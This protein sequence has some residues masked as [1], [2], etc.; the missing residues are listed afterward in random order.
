MNRP[1]IAK[2]RAAIALLIAVPLLLFAVVREK[3]SWQPRTLPIAG[4]SELQW[5]PDSKALLVRMTDEV[6][7]WDTNKKELRHS[8]KI[9]GSMDFPINL[10]PSGVLA[11]AVEGRFPH[12]CDLMVDL[13][14]LRQDKRILAPNIMYPCA[15]TRDGREIVNL[16]EG[17]VRRFDIHTGK[18]LKNINLKLPPKTFI[19]GYFGPGNGGTCSG[20][21]PAFGLLS[22]DGTTGMVNLYRESNQPVYRGW[23]NG[24]I[25][26]PIIDSLLLFDAQTGQHLV[27]LPA[28]VLPKSFD[29]SVSNFSDDNQL[30]VVSSAG[31]CQLRE[32]RTGKLKM[33]IHHP[34]IT[35]S[36][37]WLLPSCDE[38]WL[39]GYFPNGG[40]NSV[41]VWNT[42]TGKLLREINVGAIN[43]IALSP[44]AS[45]LA[46]STEE[47]TKL[48]RTR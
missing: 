40:S 9:S 1:H 42:L 14:D 18:L 34:A 4:G 22:P 15:F 20:V 46:V 19:N 44:D 35:D 29:T 48:Y 26:P 21:P 12:V 7:L 41:L 39:L 16:E 47:A 6:Y 27:R 23:A 37:Y 10:A 31:G 43:S 36:T 32:T 11:C 24:L 13:W 8:F 38:P 45:T 3:H 17:I 2:R 33:T 28:A 25:Y 5:M 30:F